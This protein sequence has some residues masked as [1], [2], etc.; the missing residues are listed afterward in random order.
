MS[1]ARR[2]AFLRFSNLPWVSF[3]SNFFFINTVHD[4]IELDVANDP[5]V[6]Y[7]SCI[8]IR[9][10]FQ[11]I[12]QLFEQHYG[13]KVN[14]PFDAECKIGFTLY[15]TGQNEKPEWNHLIKFK[16]ESFEQDWEKLITNA[17]NFRD[18]QRITADIR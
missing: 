6:V 2:D 16:P 15:E 4:D 1:L 11:R 7:N 3:G 18:H 9:K 14:V 10:S 17:K 13:T 12:P 5:E 8:E